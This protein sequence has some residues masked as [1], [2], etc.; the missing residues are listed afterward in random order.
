MGLPPR[1]QRLM[2]NAVGEGRA[3]FRFMDFRMNP[4]ADGGTRFYLR[5]FPSHDRARLQPLRIHRNPKQADARGGKQRKAPSRVV[6]LR[7][8]LL[9]GCMSTNDTNSPLK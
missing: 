7:T 2:V 6:S 4:I 5:S 3:L 1:H 8:R 9:P